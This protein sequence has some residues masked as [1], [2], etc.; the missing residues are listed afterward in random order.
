MLNNIFSRLW[1]RKN[2]FNKDRKTI[3]PMET[4]QRIESYLHFCYTLSPEAFLQL[5]GGTR[6]RVSFFTWYKAWW[7]VTHDPNPKEV[8]VYTLAKELEVSWPTAS[9]MKKKII[10]LLVEADVVNHHG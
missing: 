3:R 5:T 2:N 6:A 1:T 8:N 4:P 10:G 9:V 7:I